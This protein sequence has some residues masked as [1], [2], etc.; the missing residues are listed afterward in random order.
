LETLGAFRSIAAIAMKKY[1]A[2]YQEIVGEGDS[3]APAG[4][5]NIY[6]K[7][8]PTLEAAQHD[9]QIL[10]LRNLYDVTVEEVPLESPS[11]SENS[12]RPKL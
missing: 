8:R 4:R 7:L 12:P 5:R 10:R 11:A 3:A 1:R 2:V 9:A 6:G